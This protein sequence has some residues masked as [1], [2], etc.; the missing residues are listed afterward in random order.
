[1]MMQ[2]GPMMPPGGAMPMGGPGGPMQQGAPMPPGGPGGPQY[3]QQQQRQRSPEEMMAMEQAHI[4]RMKKDTF[5]VRRKEGRTKHG[6]ASWTVIILG[7]LGWLMQAVA[8]AM[9]DW[10]A[11]RAVVFGY[12]F[13]RGWGMFMVKGRGMTMHH[14]VS[15]KTCGWF[16][17][18]NVGNMC[19]SPLCLWYKT[20]CETYIDLTIL[21]YSCGIF[22]IIALVIHGACVIFTI[23]FTPRTIRWAATWWPVVILINGFATGTWFFITEDMFSRLNNESVYPEPPPGYCMG[24]A[25]FSFL[26]QITNCML[27]C[28]LMGW[29]PE[30]NDDSDSDSDSESDSELMAAPMKGK[31]PGTDVG[32]EQGKGKSKDK[33]KDHGKDV[34]GQGK[35]AGKDHGKK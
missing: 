8:V 13:R 31:G 19:S 9:P 29:W 14:V 11:S 7:A 6:Q 30:L 22:M 18:L 21:S 16:G 34:K 28:M 12:G 35:D 27:S 20:K 26:F 4:G 17:S 23:Q 33:G 15:Q 10:R 32:F 5:A 1:M 25:C 2:G 24:L 3:P